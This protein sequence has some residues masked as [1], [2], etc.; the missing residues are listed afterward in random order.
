MRQHWVCKIFSFTSVPL[1]LHLPFM[2]LSSPP[3]PS[4]LAWEE[5]EPLVQMCPLSLKPK[6]DPKDINST[7]QGLNQRKVSH[8]YSCF[9]LIQCDVYWAQQRVST[10]GLFQHFQKNFP[11][12]RINVN[13][14]LAHKYSGNIYLIS[15]I[16]K[17]ETRVK[18]WPLVT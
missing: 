14:E 16:T 12:E 11:T 7:E 2:S 4:K 3:F 9:P 6:H 13:V 17:V 15:A 1:F 18:V 10:L 5:E 8:K